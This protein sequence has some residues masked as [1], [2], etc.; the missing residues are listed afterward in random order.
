M[1]I[2][3]RLLQPYLIKKRTALL[4]EMNY[5]SITLIFC[6][7]KMHGQTVHT[8]KSDGS[9][10]DQLSVKRTLGLRYSPAA[11]NTGFARFIHLN[12]NNFYAA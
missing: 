11:F 8:H 6:Y 7:I 9:T 1:A 12:L 10:A 4:L 3:D 5:H 2:K